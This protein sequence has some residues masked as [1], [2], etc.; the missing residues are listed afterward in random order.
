MLGVDERAYPAQ[1]LRLGDDVIDERRLTRGL[2]PV[3]L[4]H[5]AP[6]HPSDPQRDI[7][8]ERTGR[9]RVDRDARAGIPHAH[10]G[11][12]AELPLDLGQS[13]LEGRLTLGI[14][15]LAGPRSGLVVDAHPIAPCLIR[16]EPTTLGLVADGTGTLETSAATKQDLIVPSRDRL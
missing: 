10:D 7:E 2:R 1:L 16:I 11:A 6:W 14:R 3:D 5:P 8:R 4:D 9:D 15:H 13:A 12:L